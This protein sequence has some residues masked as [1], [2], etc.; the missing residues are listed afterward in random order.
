MLCPEEFVS[1]KIC[2]Y[3]FVG[4]K[5]LFKSLSEKMWFEFRC[6][7]LVQ[8]LGQT[9][10]IPIESQPKNIVILVVVV[11]GVVDVVVHVVIV[12]APGNIPLKFG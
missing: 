8:K 7:N 11:I 4:K 3:K 12:V 2:F 10:L 6:K 9:R 5:P 1:K